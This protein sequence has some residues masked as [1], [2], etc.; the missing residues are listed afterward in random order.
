MSD[1][2][3]PFSHD[4]AFGRFTRPRRAEGGIKYQ[5]KRRDAPKAWWA[6]RW[7]S[8]LEGFDLGA[9]LQRAKTYARKGQV[10]S[11]DIQ[12]GEVSAQ[13]QGSRRQPYTASIKVT[14]LTAEQWEELGRLFASQA[15]YSAKLLSRQ[16]PVQIEN[17]FREA[18]LTL[19][20]QRESDLKTYCSCPDWSNPCKH[21]AAVY[22]L[23]G[24][25]FDRDPFLIFLLRGMDESEL[26]QLLDKEIAAS[27]SGSETAGDLGKD[28]QDG[29][30]LAS[31]TDV[32]SGF[33]RPLSTNHADFWIGKPLIS[34]PAG[35]LDE[36][37]QVAT[38]ARRLGAFP[39]WR[40]DA[41]FWPTIEA[42]YRRASS[43]TSGLLTNG[44]VAPERKPKKTKN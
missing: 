40:G 35:S 43:H 26:L 31:G 18:G 2:D 17:A 27:D 38:L 8:V 15:I 33:D 10:L 39:F 37:E 41:E 4:E 7:L 28:A 19:F 32:A 36:P 25:E 3:E 42:I 9:R 13:V 21:I 11:I 1:S 24:E 5:A 34:N 6:Q 22:L 20:P 14:P 23:L 12:K 44:D 16:M 30:Q 29:G